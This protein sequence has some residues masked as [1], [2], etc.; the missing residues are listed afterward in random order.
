MI[1]GSGVLNAVHGLGLHDH[2]CWRYEVAA[3]FLS[4]ARA[5]FQDG[6][7]RGLRVRYVAAGDP[8]VL[9][10]DLRGVEGLDEA[11]RRGAAQVASLDDTYATGDVVDPAAQVEAYAAATEEALT[12]GYA[13]LRV[14]AEATPMVRTSE[15]LEA[16]ARYEHR[17]DHFM[18]VRPFSAMCA[19]QVGQ[20]TGDAVA[21]LACMHPHANRDASPFRLYA[22]NGSDH[23]A[24]LD[25]ELDLATDELFRLAL[26][27]A[28]PRPCDGEL[29]LD[30]TGLD[31][32]DHRS[33]LQL[34]GYAG[35]RGS[36]LVLRT[37]RPGPARI[38]D[39]LGL[40]D[41]R[42]EQVA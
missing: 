39:V 14:V 20:L 32:I 9:V 25:G 2:L 15:Q 19:Y 17:I 10:E 24:A 5:F 35:A 21:Q 41:V 37:A 23:A 1:R 8:A 29:V 30:A 7:K 42:V 27:R 6:L 34:I 31:F 4:P 11:L 13:G 33:L 18:S 22:A 12:A 16:F 40:K 28:A 26:Q 3:D 38:V 36:R